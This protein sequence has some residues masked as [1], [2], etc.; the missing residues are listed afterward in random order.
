MT[1]SIRHRRAI[2]YYMKGALKKDACLRAGFSAHSVRDIFGYSDPSTIIQ[3]EVRAEIERRMRVTEKATDMDR[4]WLLKKLKLIIEASPGELIEVDKEGRPSLNF[5]HLSPSLKKVIRKITI[6]TTKEGGK[7]K[8]T[9]TNVS[10]AVPDMIGAIKEAAILLGLRQEKTKIDL[11]ESLIEAL[12]QR[13]NELA[14]D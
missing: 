3:K 1:L 9:K 2:N 10:I 7:Y 8:R 5:K 13:R 12:L 11:E 6:D 4:K 14:N